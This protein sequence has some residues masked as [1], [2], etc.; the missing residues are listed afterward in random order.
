MAES[1]GFEPTVEFYACF[2]NKCDKPDS[3]N[4]PY[5]LVEDKGIEPFREQLSAA[6]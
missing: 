6:N 3:A 2:R 5:N 1:V 4:S